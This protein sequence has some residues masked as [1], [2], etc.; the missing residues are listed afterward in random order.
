MSRDLFLV[1]HGQTL[2][3]VKHVLQGGCDSPLTELGQAQARLTGRYL[4]HVGAVFDHAYASTL[5]R[6]NETLELIRDMPYGRE[7]GLREWYFGMYEGE[8]IALLPPRPWG[9][10]FTYFGGESQD[11][12]RGRMVVTLAD[13]MARPGHERVLVVSSGSAIKEFRD[14]VDP[15]HE[16]LRVPTNCSISHYR[17]DAGRF[18]LEDIVE[19]ADQAAALGEELPGA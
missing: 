8:R 17:Y 1:R 19:L 16:E 5:Y 11:E 7:P 14:V 3:N 4:D 12:V 2:F 9:S 15:G 10:F 6:T 18:T 13:I